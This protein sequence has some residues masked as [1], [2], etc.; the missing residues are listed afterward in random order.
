MIPRPQMIP[1][2]DRKWSPTANDPRSEPQMILRKWEEWSGVEFSHGT[3]WIGVAVDNL[4]YSL[5]T[6][7]VNVEPDEQ[8]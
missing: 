6:Y 2:M 3:E 8:T 5:R 4:H 7:K 1:K